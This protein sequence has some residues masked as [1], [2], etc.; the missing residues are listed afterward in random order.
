MTRSA[1]Y[2]KDKTIYQL[3]ESQAKKTPNN[4]ALIFEDEKIKL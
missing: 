1:S 3:F 4:I 2:P